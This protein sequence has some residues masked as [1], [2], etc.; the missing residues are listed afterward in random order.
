MEKRSFKP[1]RKNALEYSIHNIDEHNQ[2]IVI[3]FSSDTRLDLPF[4]AFNAIIDY[5]VQNSDR[6][7]RIGTTLNK[8]KDHDTLE[9][10]I[11]SLDPQRKSH[12]KRAVHI[13]D[14][15]H[16]GGFI[17]FRKAVNPQTGR[18]CQAVKWKKS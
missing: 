17:D 11:Q 3:R 2:K 13:C 15:L 8:S 16:E 9:H 12:T 4:K 14:I 7:V 1:C 10:V 18:L 5:L 6:F